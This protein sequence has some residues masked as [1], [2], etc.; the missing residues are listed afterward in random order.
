MPTLSRIPA[1]RPR[2]LIGVTLTLALVCL[3]SMALP[4]LTAIAGPKASKIWRS[5]AKKLRSA[6][7]AEAK[8]DYSLA[9]ARSFLLED[10]DQKDAIL[11]AREEYSDQKELAGDTYRARLALASDL[12]EA[13]LYRVD[14]D[15]AD[16]VT[17]VNHPLMPLTPGVTRTYEAETEDGRETIV[18]TVLADTR[19]I[20]GV[21]CVVVR[22]TVSI[23]GELVEDTLDWY[24][25]DREGNVWYFGEIALNY[26][27]GRLIDVEGSWEAGVDGA[28]PGIIM[29]AA[30]A[31]G[32]RYRQEFLLGEAEDFALVLALAESVTVPAGTWHGCLITLDGTPMEPD[33]IEHKYY[34]TGVGVVLEENPE[35]GER[36]ELV[37]ITSK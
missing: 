9:V 4:Q 19:E 32:D 20:L 10:E 37:S 8:A 36:V 7:K 35:S 26:E 30:P 23:D 2:S 21:T 14:I 22:D 25:Q 16:F 33:V 28:Q 31:V 27:E 24:A 1:A 3:V 15:P 12:T 29:P 5:V 11:E 34:A 6:A 13:D 17:G 18:V